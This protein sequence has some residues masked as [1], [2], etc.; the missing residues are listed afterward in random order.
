MQNL[1]PK[2]QKAVTKIFLEN[3]FKIEIEIQISF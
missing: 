2:T 1:I 3:T